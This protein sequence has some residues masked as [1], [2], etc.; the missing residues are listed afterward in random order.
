M[1]SRVKLNSNTCSYIGIHALKMATD[2]YPEVMNVMIKKGMLCEYYNYSMISY[3][4]WVARATHEKSFIKSTCIGTEVFLSITPVPCVREYT[5]RE[6]L[7]INK[8]S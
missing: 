8:H 3:V 5:S 7:C 6:F 2:N 1:L 4:K